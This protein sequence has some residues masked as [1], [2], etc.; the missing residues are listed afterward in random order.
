MKKSLLFAA[1][2]A[3]TA[4]LA[5]QPALGRVPADADLVCVS[6]SDPALDAAI[7]KAWQPSFDKVGLTKDEQQKAREELFGKCPQLEPFLKAAFGYNDD[8]TVSSAT[9]C[10]VSAKLP[11]FEG[12]TK[13]P[14]DY[15]MYL[16]V[17][18]PKADLPAM[19]KLAREG[20]AEHFSDKVRLEK[21]G[22]WCVLKPMGNGLDD[23][24]FLGW[25]GVEG[26]WVV[27]IAETQAKADAFLTGKTPTLQAGDKLAEAFKAPAQ[28]AYRSS[29]IVKDVSGLIERYL[30]DEPDARQQL[31]MAANWLFKTSALRY[32]FLT[33]A[34]RC[35]FALTL[36]APDA[37]TA[38]LLRDQLVTFKVMLGQMIIPMALQKA[39]SAFAKLIG[40]TEVTLT[41]NAA[42]ATLSIS[43]DQF[44]AALAEIKAFQERLQA[45][46]AG[47][48]VPQADD[49]EET[50]EPMS[51]EEAKAILD[52]LEL[53]D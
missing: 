22:D 14:R 40:A 16:F 46:T 2:F 53:D 41:G 7:Q 17:D 35:T 12:E 28:D 34:D 6:V 25:R 19:E 32:D 45:E 47:P 9:G 50:L 10:L 43:P 36:E 29:V 4:P 24:P 5:A 27:A 26:G 37:E 51:E 18:N 48:A 21:V 38:A 31:M 49:A 39:D 1:L 13:T 15:W 52:G 42:T 44:A 8:F 33:T 30:A 3:L 23:L 11:T 20:I